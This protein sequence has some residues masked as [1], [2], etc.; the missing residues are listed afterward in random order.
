MN[1]NFSK[2]KSHTHK[3]HYF[4]T[5]RY[6]NVNNTIN[7]IYLF[8]NVQQGISN[9]PGKKKILKEDIS[10]KKNKK[11]LDWWQTC[12]IY[13][14]YPRSFKDS[15]GTG[16][17]DLHGNIRFLTIFYL[18]TIRLLYYVFLLF[19]LYIFPYVLIVI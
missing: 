16:V 14:L 13:E 5:N 15:T 10:S 9:C 1:F 8:L 19:S 2:P 3:T 7:P 12:I 4:T 6:I 18:F 17:G 11:N